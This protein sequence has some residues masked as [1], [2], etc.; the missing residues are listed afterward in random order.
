MDQIFKCVYHLWLCKTLS[1]QDVFKPWSTVMVMLMGFLLSEIYRLSCVW[2]FLSLDDWRWDEMRCREGRG[3]RVSAWG[4]EQLL[5]MDAAEMMERQVVQKRR[6]TEVNMPGEVTDRK[7]GENKAICVCLGGP[8]C[9]HLIWINEEVDLCF[10]SSLALSTLSH[11]RNRFSPK[12]HI[13]ISDLSWVFFSFFHPFQVLDLS[14]LA[15][16]QTSWCCLLLGPPMGPVPTASF[17]W[18]G[19][20]RSTEN[21]TVHTSGTQ[22]MNVLRESLVRHEDRNALT[23]SVCTA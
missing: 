19:L 4:T 14:A 11:R 2:L 1:G 18:S 5:K 22:S 13:S 3:I 23:A 7:E 21:T 17:G 16:W 6:K 12:L 15:C 9:S 8:R 20:S 10:F